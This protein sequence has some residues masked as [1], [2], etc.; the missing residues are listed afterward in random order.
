[1]CQ[2]ERDIVVL[3]N[4][5]NMLAYTFSWGCATINLFRSFC[6]YVSRDILM[7]FGYFHCIKLMLFNPRSLNLIYLAVREMEKNAIKMVLKI[8]SSMTFMDVSLTQCCFQHW[9]E[10]SQKGE[11]DSHIPK[12]ILDI[13]MTIRKEFIWQISNFCF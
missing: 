4:S 10:I 12:I 13:R 5:S 1:M 3:E 2:I 7:L 11:G 9:I 6:V 8:H